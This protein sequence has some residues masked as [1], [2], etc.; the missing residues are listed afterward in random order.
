MEADGRVRQ[1]KEGESELV[2]GGGCGGRRED[3]RAAKCQSF[4][5]IRRP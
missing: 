3:E 1:E 4:E 2:E 5:F